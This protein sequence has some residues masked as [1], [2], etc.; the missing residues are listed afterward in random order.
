MKR[1]P[2]LIVGV[3]VGACFMHVAHSLEHGL[4]EL[5]IYCGGGLLAGLVIDL[6]FAWARRVDQ[7]GTQNSPLPESAAS[8]LAGLFRAR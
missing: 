6:L 2:W 3:L 1:V 8:T 5:V 7:G 4:W